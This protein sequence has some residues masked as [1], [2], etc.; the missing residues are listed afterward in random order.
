M[1]YHIVTSIAFQ[2]HSKKKYSPG[3]ESGM[4]K[5][6]GSGRHS[7]DIEV[8]GLSVIASSIS[9]SDTTAESLRSSKVSLVFLS[10]FWLLIDMFWRV[11]P[12]FLLHLEISPLERKIKFV[13]DFSSAHKLKI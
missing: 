11:A 7:F 4:S 13:I 8:I 2:I 5:F 3:W 1:N 10:R 9:V 12:M 6:V